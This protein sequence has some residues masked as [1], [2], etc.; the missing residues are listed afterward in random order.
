MY[1]AKAGAWAFVFLMAVCAASNITGAILNMRLESYSV[2]GLV[3]VIVGCVGVIIRIDGMSIERSEDYFRPRAV[4][5]WLPVFLGL[6]FSVISTLT[7]LGGLW[8]A[9]TFAIM[10][11][12]RRN[13][14]QDA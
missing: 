11:V 4:A 1:W 3:L 2:V 13:W 12:Y 9:M 14:E 7:I 8:L 5:V 6:L 10:N